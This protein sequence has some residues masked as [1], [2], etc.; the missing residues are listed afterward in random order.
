LQQRRGVEV[1]SAKSLKRPP[2]SPGIALCLALA[3]TLAPLIAAAQVLPQVSSKVPPAIVFA[4][5][6]QGGDVAGRRDDYVLAIS[7]L[8]RQ[9]HLKS[10]Q[11]VSVDA[12]IKHQA[13]LLKDWSER[14]RKLM[15]PALERFN[16]FI[17]PFKLRWPAR[18]LLVRTDPRLEDGASFTR[19]NAAFLSDQAM[20]NAGAAHYFL[21]H[22][23]FHILSRHDPALRE[24]LYAAIGFTRCARA[25]IPER[26]ARIRITNPDAVE[27]MHTIK[28]RH[29]GQPVEALPYIRFSAEPNPTGGLFEQLENRWL[30]VD[31]VGSECKVRQTAEG[32]PDVDPKALEGLFEQIGRNSDYLFGPEEIL[33]DNFAILFLAWVEGGNPP[34]PSP[35]VLEKI[36]KIL[37]NP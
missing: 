34:A 33:A 36:R 26:I 28:V 29:R 11:P 13:A 30:L 18:I 23:A 7:P 9:V 14:D 35:E 15:A 17:A 22:E 19:G 2:F 10:A 25:D 4:T 27:N 24:K 21:A 12:F 5:A 37:L 8:E 32:V 31:R 20:H 1:H 3:G 6:A 16:R